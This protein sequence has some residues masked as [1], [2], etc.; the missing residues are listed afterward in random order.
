MGSIVIPTKT[1][2]KST[3]GLIISIPLMR[4][5]LPLRRWARIAICDTIFN[6]RDETIWVE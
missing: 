5:H 4:I 6:R 3:L 1:L 2:E